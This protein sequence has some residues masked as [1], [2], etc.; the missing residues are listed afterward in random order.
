MFKLRVRTIFYDI[1]FLNRKTY[2]KILANGTMLKGIYLL[3]TTL[4]STPGNVA[5][6]ANLNLLQQ[7][8]ANVHLNGI[9]CMDE[10]WVVKGIKIYTSDS[11]DKCVG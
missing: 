6:V 5:L 4:T 10:H 8:F 9:K 1:T 11:V 2:N 7:R 3:Y